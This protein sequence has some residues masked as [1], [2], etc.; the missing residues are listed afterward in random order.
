MTTAGGVGCHG[1][2]V[3]F[4][5]ISFDPP[6]RNRVAT[7]L[8]E[9]QWLGA[10]PFIAVHL[11]PLLAFWTGTRWQDWACCVALYWV[12]MFGVTGV[13]HRYFAHRTYK[14]SRVF[15]FLLALLAMS[16]SQKGVLW[17]AS[18]HRTHHRLSDKDGDPHDSRR[19]FWYSHVGWLYDYREQTDYSKVKDL[20]RYPELVFLN[21]Y[22]AIPPLALGVG[23]WLALGWS[24][25][26]IGF[27]LSTAILWHGT[28]TINSLSHMLGSRRYETGEDSKNNWVLAIITMGEGWHNNHHHF[29]GSTRQGFYWWEFDMSYYIVRGLQALGLVW[30]IKEPP[31]RV[32]D[33]AQQLPR[34]DGAVVVSAPPAAV[35]LTPGE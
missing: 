24:G 32:Y 26:L 15:Q 22:W 11:L 17:W 16:S 33:P 31:A 28:F 3:S 13:Y 7:K 19:G 10:A 21:E 20:A 14:T 35:D 25:L 2:R 9:Y 12:R 4:L 34:G 5:N 18:N 30:D 27:F 29:M 6:A 1:G 23:V 8:S